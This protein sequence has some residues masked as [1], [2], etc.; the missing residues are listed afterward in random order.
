MS[1]AAPILLVCMARPE[2][3]E[4]RPGWGAG[5][6]ALTT[7]LS[8]L[9]RTDCAELT[10]GLLGEHA[11]SQLLE[12]ITDAADGIPLFVEEMLAMLVDL[13]RLVSHPAGGWTATAD[14]TDS[15]VPA[16]V[17]ALLAARLDQL[18]SQVRTVID[19]AS[20]VGK[21]FY[22]DAVAVLLNGAPGMSESIQALVR[23]DLIAA[24]ATDLP[25]HDAYT[26][27]HLLT[28]DTAYRMLPK[29]R[30]AGLHLALA[31]WL[32]QDPGAAF[33][34]EVV[35]FHLEQAASYQAELGRPDL[36]LAEEAAGL[37]LTAADRAMALG[38][39]SAAGALARRAEPLA[40]AGSRLRTEITLTRSNVAHRAGHH[41]EAI[42]LA[43]EAERVGATLGDGA[44]QW[45]ATLQ[46]WSVRAYFDPSYRVDDV[47]ALVERAINTS[48]P[49]TTTSALRMRSHSAPSPTAGSARCGPGLPTRCKGCGTPTGS[50]TP[51][52]TGMS[53]SAR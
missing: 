51:A 42:R 36:A 30:R 12:R 27:T 18:P 44:M 14:L 40:P 19:A 11:G 24:T 17:Q 3:L 7:V 21:T 52:G 47:F 8:P 4:T 9:S 48:P 26:F 41:A 35:A 6:Q 37:L 23:A 39:I 29:T 53:S 13:G 45:R 10:A 49:S 15:T 31:R 20:V 38:D 43:E 32:Q 28:R 46:K 5:R 34:S 25:G 16:T 1:R 22:P 33:S 2:F 50:T